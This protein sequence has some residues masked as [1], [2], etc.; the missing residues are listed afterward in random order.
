M[1]SIFKRKQQIG[2]TPSKR[3]ASEQFYTPIS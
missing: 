2:S 1:A 3:A